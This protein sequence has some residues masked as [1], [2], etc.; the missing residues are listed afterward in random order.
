MSSSGMT[1]RTAR[2]RMCLSVP[3]RVLTCGR[4]AHRQLDELV[5]EE[6]HPALQADAHAHLVHAHEQQLREPVVQVHV[7][8]PVQVGLVPCPGPEPLVG[9]RQCVPR[10]EVGELLPE[11]RRQQPLL[12]R[13]REGLGAAPEDGLPQRSRDAGARSGAIC[14][15]PRAAVPARPA[16]LSGRGRADGP[17]A[18]VTGSAATRDSR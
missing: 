7:G 2:L 12:L 17:A 9:R 4:D 13:L 11:P 5:V 14:P 18:A 15:F 16:R 10:G 1:P 6:R 8:H 3:F